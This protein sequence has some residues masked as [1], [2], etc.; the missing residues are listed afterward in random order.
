MNNHENGRT[1]KSIVQSSTM[2]RYADVTAVAWW[3]GSA[4]LRRRRVPDSKPYPTESPPCYK[5]RECSMNWDSI[6]SNSSVSS[7]GTVIN[8][9]VLKRHPDTCHFCGKTL[10]FIATGPT[11]QRMATI[12]S[13][14]VADSIIFS[15]PPSDVWSV[16]KHSA[17]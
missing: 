9:A 15:P 13:H 16:P 2:R 12:L 14:P 1:S 11:G 4:G 7:R 6:D 5:E 10:M 3:L 8:N 17:K